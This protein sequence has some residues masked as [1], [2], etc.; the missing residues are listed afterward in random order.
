MAAAGPGWC[1]VMLTITE[2]QMIL[3]ADG[4]TLAGVP[5]GQDPRHVVGRGQ[6]QRRQRCRSLIR[7]PA[8]TGTSESP[9]RTSAATA[10]AVLLTAATAAGYRWTRPVVVKPVAAGSSRGVTLVAESGGLP[11]ALDAAFALD[12]RVLAE[13]VITG[14][15][16]DLA[17]LAAPMAPA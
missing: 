8:A 2:D 13:D 6:Q 9:S 12:D 5:A 10:P 4:M 17:V 3:H 15:E 11:A 1:P 14:R 16:I 7:S